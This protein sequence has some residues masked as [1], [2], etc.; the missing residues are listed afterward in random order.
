MPMVRKLDAD[1]WEIR[2]RIDDK[3]ARVFFTVKGRKM[4]L[5]HGII[6]KSQ[7]TPADALKLAKRRRNSL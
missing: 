3:I 1:L 4:V 5:L 2:T 6:K 7:S